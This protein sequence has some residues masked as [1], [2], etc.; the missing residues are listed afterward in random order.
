MGARKTIAQAE[1]RIGKVEFVRKMRVAWFEW[2][3]LL[4]ADYERVLEELTLEGFSPSLRKSQAG[5][6][7]MSCSHPISCSQ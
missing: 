2:P 1:A 3:S 6:V 4:A 7:P 5:Q